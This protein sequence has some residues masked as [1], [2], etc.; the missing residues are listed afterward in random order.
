[1][2]QAQ[3]MTEVQ[4][5]ETR[6]LVIRQ[7]NDLILKQRLLRIKSKYPEALRINMQM[8][9]KEFTNGIISVTEYVPLHFILYFD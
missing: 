1:M 9:E 3:S 6:Q 2:G 7:Y 4:R 8:V 5:D